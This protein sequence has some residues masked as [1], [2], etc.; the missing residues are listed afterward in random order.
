MLRGH[1]LFSF[2]V[3]FFGGLFLRGFFYTRTRLWSNLNEYLENADLGRCPV[4]LLKLDNRFS[5]ML[6]HLSLVS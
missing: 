2:V 1:C 3:C 4:V 5:T 6:A